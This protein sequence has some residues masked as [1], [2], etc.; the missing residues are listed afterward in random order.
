VRLHLE[1]TVN[2]LD[3]L[4]Y[5]ARK[6]ETPRYADVGVRRAGLGRERVIH[7]LQALFVPPQRCQQESIPVQGD[8]VIRVLRQQRFELAGCLL[9]FPL[10]EEADQ[11]LDTARLGQL[12]I[13]PSSAEV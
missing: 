7:D 10:V 9:P 13:Q 3:R 8:A 1:H 5:P 2:P 11:A 12:R 6:T 4:V